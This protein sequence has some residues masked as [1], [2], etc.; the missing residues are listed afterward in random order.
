MP[1]A[2][3][4]GSGRRQLLESFH[5]AE[6]SAHYPHQLSGGM[7]QRVALAR[8]LAVD[9]TVLLLDEPFSA[10]DAQTRMALQRDLAQTLKRA[11]KTALLITHDLLEAVTLSDRVLVMSRRPGHII[12]EIPVDVPAR[13]DPIARRKDAKVNGYVARLMDRLDIGALL[14]EPAGRGMT[15]AAHRSLMRR[16]TVASLALLV[17]FVAGWEW[18]PGLLR[19]PTFII[20]PLSMV[21][22]EAVRM[23]EV[24]SLLFHS[25][26]TT[27]EVLV[28]FAIGSLFGAVIGYLL[29]MSPT[30]EV[31]LS[32]YILALQIAPKVAFAPLFILW[33]GFTVYPKILVAILIV[34]F[35]VMVNVLTS[36]RTVDPDLV[37][38]ARSFKATRA[39]I[40]WK[41]EFPSLDAAD[42]R[43]A[44]HRVDAGRDRR[45]R[46]R[47]G[48]RQYG[49]RLP[50]GLRRGPGQYADG[51]RLD[52]DADPDRRH[53]L[54]RRHPGRAARAALSAQACAGWDLKGHCIGDKSFVATNPGGRPSRATRV[55]P[56]SL[57]TLRCQE[58]AMTPGRGPARAGTG[59]NM[60]AWP[61]GNPG[62]R[63]LRWSWHGTKVFRT[64]LVIE[65]GLQPAEI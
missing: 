29:G 20:P 17:L 34:F 16:G 49:A 65:R 15:D 6:F 36:I 54:S 24:N 4:A 61:I 31:A 13:D 28:G 47:T 26:I 58:P 46:R 64:A 51:I 14:E 60:M 7:R 30:A 12:D 62:K 5:L 11:G 45:R 9:P 44:A 25:G 55:Q 8:T 59:P 19:I 48:R 18:G 23:W 35:P 37:N 41:I 2:R 21:A 57:L 52:P 50:S 33:M 56:A 42:V 38:L 3:S 10:V 43:G 27:A 63:G 32:P 40:F 22:K 1:S 53:C 39:Q